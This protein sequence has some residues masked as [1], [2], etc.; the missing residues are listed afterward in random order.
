MSRPPVGA[1]MPGERVLWEGRPGWRALA[2]DVLHI[3][4][5]AL[6]LAAM[7]IWGA[8][9]DRAN[10]AGPV[11]TFLAELPLFL[12]GLAVLGACAGFAMACA[13]TTRYTVTTERCILR[14]GVALTGTLSLPLRRVASIAVAAAEDGT[15]DILLAL[16]PGPGVRF[17]KAWPHVRPWRFSRPQP[18]L[19]CVSDGV[20]VAALLS[21]AAAGVSPGVLH[22]APATKPVVK[23]ARDRSIAAP[24]AIWPA[25]A[26]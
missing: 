18:M 21:Q 4:W 3:H 11:D 7:L 23:P 19:R 20:A 6:Y 25:A 9:S 2:R 5:V 15:A 16:K 17:L 22:A 26:D 14:Y 12:L 10:G 24:A 8:A 13:R 1:M